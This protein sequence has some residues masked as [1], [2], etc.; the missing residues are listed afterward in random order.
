VRQYITRTE[1]ALQQ[2]GFGAAV[3]M[4]SEAASNTKSYASLL[5][6]PDHTVL[7]MVSSTQTIGGRSAEVLFLRSE[8]ADGIVVVTTNGRVKRRFPRRPGYDVIAFPD[9]SDP[10]ALLALHRFRLS[11]RDGG[12]PPRAVT[13]G[14]DPLAYQ[15]REGAET[16]E[17]FVRVGYYRRSS[18]DVLQ[19][20]LKGAVCLT[21]RGMFPWAQMSAARDE[22][23]RGRVLGRYKGSASG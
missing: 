7:A 13:R 9:F 8:A 22:R 17:Y 23:D 1:G 20:T 19:P 2:L 3:R 10:G 4:C 6:H 21:W 18:S 14:T 11:D 5:E 16:Y 12:A 15:R